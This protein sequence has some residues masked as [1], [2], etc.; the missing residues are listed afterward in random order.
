MRKEILVMLA[1]LL[2]LM[3]VGCKPIIPP[4]PEEVYATVAGHVTY[5]RG[6]PAISDARVYG[7]GFETFTDEKG[8]FEIAVPAEKKFDLFVDKGNYSKALVQDIFLEED[9]FLE[10]EI[11]CRKSFHP[12]WS[13]EPLRLVVDGVE[14]GETISG[15]IDIAISEKD[16]K[17]VRFCYLYFNGTYSAF[18][19][20]EIPGG[21]K[22]PVTLDTSQYPEGEGFIA[23]YAYDFNENLT[24][25]TIP[26]FVDGEQVPPSEDVPGNI[27]NFFV[28]TLTVDE[29]IGAYSQKRQAAFERLN[30]S[31]NPNVL[32]LESGL[33]IDLNV[34]PDDV[35]L[36]VYLYW[37][38]PEDAQ[39]CNVYR[40]FDGVDYKL[41]ST[42]AGP[43]HACNDWGPELSL[44]ETIYY[45]VV[46]Y[47]DKGE[48]P[49]LVRSVTPLP[50]F[51]IQLLEPANRSFDV[52]LQ[53]VFEWDT[54]VVFDYDVDIH[55]NIW[56][57]YAAKPIYWEE[58]VRT[59]IA[60]LPFE[61]D[62]SSAYTWDVFEAQA[63]VYCE[64]LGPDGYSSAQSIAPVGSINGEFIFT[65]LDPDK[66]TD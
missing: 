19:A 23:I 61:L 36:V 18:A 57:F 12:E 3:S 45:K 46:P 65:T 21:D 59:N 17:D 4:G 37:A 41:I 43:A 15:S 31:A 35:S 14:R 50:P 63:F 38:I 49:G 56:L 27:T 6:G 11:P 22:Y 64:P 51:H 26:V 7:I 29:T 47:N 25:Y 48:G 52:P 40:S 39:G 9:G 13:Q 16:G 10:L 42:V 28:N 55:Y 66:I 53:P 62:P 5:T 34:I 20:S 8:Y 33:P 60:R 1:V 54:S 30:I 58:K 32:E 24:I 44:N 2:I